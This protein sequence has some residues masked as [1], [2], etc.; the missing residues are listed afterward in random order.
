MSLPLEICLFK[1]LVQAYLQF[2]EGSFDLRFE[3]KVTLLG[4]II[5]YC[6]LL[7]RKIIC[8]FRLM[9]LFISVFPQCFVAIDGEQTFNE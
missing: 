4:L 2:P 9:S 7:G 3:K 5:W 6:R 1:I 8:A